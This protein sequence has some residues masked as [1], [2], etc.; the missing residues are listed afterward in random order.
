MDHRR[1]ARW[2]WLL[3]GV[4]ALTAVASVPRGLVRATVVAELSDSRPAHTAGP[5][6]AHPEQQDY[7]LPGVRAYVAREEQPVGVDPAPLDGTASAAAVEPPSASHASVGIA[8]DRA[9]S[10]WATA[11]VPARAPPESI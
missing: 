11:R 5:V 3:L 1:P 9:S 10:E 6:V 8:A 4:V 7:S 2:C